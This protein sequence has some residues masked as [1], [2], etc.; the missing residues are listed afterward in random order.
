MAVNFITG[1]PGA[2]KT[3]LTDEMVMRG[4]TAYDTDD[5][6]RTGMAGWHD[7]RT[8]EY[9]AG[10]N[11]IPLTDELF[12][13][14]VWRLTDSAIEDFRIRG[15]N[16]LIYLS[17]R[18]KSP[19]SVISICKHIVFL[20]VSGNVIDARL[21]A[22]SLMP[23]VVEW[24]SERS[25]IDRSIVIN[26]EITEEYRALGAIMINAERPIAEIANDIIAATRE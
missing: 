14:H 17:G 13:T 6:G 19:E 26:E 10:F 24:G 21:T 9:V 20:T 16:E 3:T 2:G 11:E 8:K 1:A 5:P 18:L 12:Q 25:Q 4:Y 23:G 15:R 22:R 7:L